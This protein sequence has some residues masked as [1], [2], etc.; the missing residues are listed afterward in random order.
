MPLVTFDIFDNWALIGKCLGGQC[1]PGGGVQLHRTESPGKASPSAAEPLKWLTGASKPSSWYKEKHLTI[2]LPL[3]AKK[4]YSE[5]KRL[6]EKPDPVFSSVAW[7]F[8]GTWSRESRTRPQGRRPGRQQGPLRPELGLSQGL[9][10]GP[11]AHYR[12]ERA[13]AIL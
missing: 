2:L 10:R 11:G 4:H 5:A 1:V 9:C 12:P 13:H 3:E 6:E 7:K 8:K